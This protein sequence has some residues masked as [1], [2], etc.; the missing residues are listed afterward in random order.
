MKP[1]VKRRKTDM[2]DAEAISE[3]ASR[4]TMRFGA[5]QSAAQQAAAMADRIRDL[6]VRQRTQTTNALRAHLA[7][8]G[9]VAPTGP[10]HVVRLAAIIYGEDGLLPEAMR[11]LARLLLDQIARLDEKIAG[12]EA[13]PRR[14]V[15]ADDTCDG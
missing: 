14:R 10:A 15:T 2:A 9:T 1:F 5:V 11:D 12:L 4:P 3:A 7:E 8:Q 13:E 6:L